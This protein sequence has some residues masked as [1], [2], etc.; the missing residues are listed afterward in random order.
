MRD[1]I[2]FGTMKI[3]ALF[4]KLL[5]PTVL[6]MVFSAAFVITDGVFVGHGIGSD[7]LAAVNIAAPLF[8][9]TAGVSLLFGMGASVTASIHLS[10]GKIKVARLQ[11]TQA[12]VV[13]SLLIILFSAG[14]IA[15]STKISYLLGSSDKLLPLV[16][17]YL[18][19]FVPFLVFHTILTAGMFFIRL[20]GSPHYAM[21]CNAV[22]AVLNIILDYIFIFILKWGML[23][24]ALATSLGYIIG[25]GM[26]LFYLWKRANTLLLHKI[27]LSKNSLL[28]MARNVGYMCRLGMSAFLCETSIAVMMFVGNYVFINHLGEDGV[29]AF[30]IACYF[31]PLIFMIY[32]AIGASAQPILS[33]NYGANN[34]MR[35]KQAFSWAFFTAVGCGCFFLM[36]TILFSNS[37]VSLFISNEYPAHQI[38]AQGLPFFALGFPFFGANIVSIIYFQ[39]VK[40][41]V[42]ATLITIIRGFVLMEVCLYLLPFALGSTGIWLGVPFAEILV[43]LLIAITYKQGKRQ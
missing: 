22:P 36:L 40:R 33:Y 43:F 27:K 42:Y 5:I 32:N 6:G 16:L 3:P 28:L 37:I 20:D 13:A 24:A 11:V 2:D 9:I 19:W 26:I 34:P 41:A 14:T 17:E 35:V 10:Q 23:G 12:L 25:A 15:C 31:F 1:S 38:A 4:G 30:S 29:A 21:W 7:A 8:L 39:S 18:H